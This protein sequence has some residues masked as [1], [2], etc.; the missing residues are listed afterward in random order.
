MYKVSILNGEK[1]TVIHS[2]HVNG[3]KLES[4]TIKKEINKTDSFDMGFYLNNPA[5]GNLK[6]F[7]TLIK[8]LNTKTHE[9]EF[10]GRVLDYEERMTDEGLITHDYVCEG[11]LG[12]LHDSQQRH[13]EFRGTPKK[14]LHDLLTYHNEQVEEY[15]RFYPGVMEVTTSTD[16]LYVYLSAESST[17]DEIDDKILERVGGELRIRKEY[18]KRYLDVLERVGEDKKN[19]IKIAKNLK[20][21][22][23]NVNPTDIVTRLTP[24]GTRVESEDE[25][26]T[27]ASE[28]R[29]TI[30]EVN[31]GLPYIDRQDLIDEFGIRGGSETW[32]DITLPNRLLSTGRNWL[33][34]QKLVLYQYEVS[35]I[36]LSL[37]GL[38]I[39]S[40]V[41][42]NSHPVRNPLMNIDEPLRII[43][44]TTNINDP[45]DAALK[46]G[47]KFKNLD[48]YQADANRSTRKVN[49]LEN[50]VI[51]QSRRINQQSES[52]KQAQE[53]LIELQELIDAID[54][55]N[56]EQTLI[57]VTQQLIEI[58]EDINQIGIEI[59]DFQLQ[60]TNL[61]TFKDNQEQIN[62]DYMDFKEQYEI[63]KLDI[64]SRLEILEGGT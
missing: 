16:N 26:A 1:E 33:N 44:T 10:E 22:S 8:V 64:L 40:F 60:I 45:E 30:E 61:N 32:D 52:L 29:L 5:Y 35:A 17:K 25:G 46:I 57:L 54:E 59:S 41:I 19:T 42:G 34:N 9:Y 28:A 12:Y 49:E 53:K 63:T 2:P 39:D 6:P 50:T 21:I 58:S 11:E 47:D 43:G 56:I 4:G 20:S 55:E 24:L 38:D 37:I 7:K 62:D 23:V 27:D 18:G 15:K 48:D 14:L 13:L 36:D 51:S 3:L 31:N